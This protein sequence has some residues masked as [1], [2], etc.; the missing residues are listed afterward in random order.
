VSYCKGKCGSSNPVPPL[1]CYCDE[2]CPG[3][4]DCC[5]DYGSVCNPAAGVGQVKCGNGTCAVPA[6]FCCVQFVSG[7][8]LNPHCQTAG[9][10][11]IGPDVFCDGPEDC[12]G[13]KICCSTPVG[14]SSLLVECRD[15]ALCKD[16][17]Q[18]II[19]GNNPAV[20]PSGDLCVPNPVAPQ[21]NY[22]Q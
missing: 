15:P 14:G 20:C 18:R 3:S 12:S 10:Q 1:N 22:C 4:N 8:G 11:C 21:Y 7:G 13:G 9:T 5:P 6:S 16:S 17:S 19:C 2:Q